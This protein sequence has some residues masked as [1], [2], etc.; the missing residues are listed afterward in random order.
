MVSFYIYIYV[1]VC[2]AA[3]LSSS[4]SSASRRSAVAL[5]RKALAALSKEF[6]ETIRLERDR[7]KRL[8]GLYVIGKTP[9]LSLPLTLSLAAGTAEP[10]CMCMYVCIHRHEQTRKPADRQP[11]PR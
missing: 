11:A 9:S 3:P 5:L 2:V 8:G 10:V 6:D 4:S 7:V 1:C